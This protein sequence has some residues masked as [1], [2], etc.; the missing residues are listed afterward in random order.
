LTKYA[1]ILNSLKPVENAPPVAEPVVKAADV[2]PSNEEIIGGKAIEYPLRFTHPKGDAANP[3]TNKKAES[4][5]RFGK[6]QSSYEYV[7]QSLKTPDG[8]P[9][10][11]PT[12]KAVPRE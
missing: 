1:D 12:A 2:V 6:G 5:A 11:V 10:L 9:G 4:T 8:P 3:F 7:H